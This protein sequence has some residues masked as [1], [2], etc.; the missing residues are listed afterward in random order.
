MIVDPYARPTSRKLLYGLNPLA[1]IAAP[2][3]AMVLLVFVR[4][5]A[6]PLVFLALAYGVLLAGARL[7]RGLVLLLAVVVP[8]AALFVGLGMSLWADASRV[9]QGIAVVRLGGWTLYGGAV[10]I[11]L[12]TGLRLAAIVALALS[13]GHAFIL[14]LGPGFYPVN[15]LK[16]VQATPE[17]CRIFCATANPTQV[18]LAESEQGRGIL[19]VIDGMHTQGVEDGEGV[20]WRKGFL[21]MIGYKL[22]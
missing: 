10:A 12:A 2:L 5:L 8:A 21:R 4:D 15:V 7:T 17:V 6:T 22:G 3:P 14:F 9:D 1:K 16:T 20:A 19:G 18:I 11:G 13:A